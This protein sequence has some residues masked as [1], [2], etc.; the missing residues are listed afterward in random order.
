MSNRFGLDGGI[1]SPKPA[2]YAGK[3]Q[4]GAG[5][6]YGRMGIDGTFGVFAHDY[7]GKDT[8]TKTLSG[9]VQ[10]GV[11]TV[12]G[13]ID[14]IGDTLISGGVQAQQPTLSGSVFTDKIVSGGVASETV[15]I[16]GQL[17]MYPQPGWTLTAFTVDYA[18][19]SVL[20]PFAGDN[21]YETLSD[22]DKCH[23]Q[24]TTSPDSHTMVMSGDGEFTITPTSLTQTQ[25]F[26]FQI[27]DT[28]VQTF[29]AVG[30]ITVLPQIGAT[31]SGGVSA[32]SSTVSGDV[33]RAVT[34]SGG[35]QAGNSTVFGVITS[36]EALEII[37]GGVQAQ[38]SVLTGVIER[39]ITIPGVGVQAQA[40]EVTGTL[41]K[42]VHISGNAQA[43][44]PVLSGDL[45]PPTE[46]PS[47]T[48]FRELAPKF[49]NRK[50]KWNSRQRR[51]Q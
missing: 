42:I 28:S 33:E 49:I 18:G 29:G 31:I 32:Q 46:D 14:R 12:T 50:L 26:N 47:T 20:S 44:P 5:A 8:T 23:F 30:T 34:L 35:V 19:L 3:E 40:A 43:E 9:G 48:D 39:I 4:K 2:S 38:D 10:A 27:Y 37:V 21:T 11:A 7:T 51:I 25:Q 15:T 16:A 6:P 45:R 13:D 17:N 22:G 24:T 36:E 1:G 41:G